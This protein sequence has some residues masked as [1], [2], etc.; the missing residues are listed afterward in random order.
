MSPFSR[1]KCSHQL[2]RV[3]SSDEVYRLIFVIMT[4]ILLIT[5]LISLLS[6]SLS[7]VSNMSASIS[8][9]TRQ[10]HWLFVL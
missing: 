8:V 2:L 1:D 5:S 7:E 6:N 3:M 10:E 9:S 4:N